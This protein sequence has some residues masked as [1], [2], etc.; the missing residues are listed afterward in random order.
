[1]HITLSTL[2][3]V[4]ICI[5]ISTIIFSHPLNLFMQQVGIVVILKTGI[6]SEAC[7]LTEGFHAFLQP[8]LVNVMMVPRFANQYFQVL[9]WERE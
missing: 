3:T 2:K 9:F 5:D 4:G 8:F 6:L 7:Y 1:M